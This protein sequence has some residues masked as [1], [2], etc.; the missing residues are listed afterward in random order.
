M[1]ACCVVPSQKRLDGVC[2]Y[3]CLPAGKNW[4]YEAI[5][6][7]TTLASY[8]TFNWAPILV[9]ANTHAALYTFNLVF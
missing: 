4:Q 9:M 3:Y 5:V 2:F 6:I 8:T 1:N 7:V